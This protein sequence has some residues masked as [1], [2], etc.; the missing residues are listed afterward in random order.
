M[1]LLMADLPLQ[2]ETKSPYSELIATLPDEDPDTDGLS[3]A[4][5]AEVGSNPKNPDTDGDGLQDGEDAVAII[6]AMKV[7]AAKRTNYAIIDLGPTHAVGWPK[8][9]ND[10]GQVLLVAYNYSTQQYQGNLWEGGVVRLVAELEGFQGEGFHGL[11]NDGTVYYSIFA[12][13]I[14]CNNEQNCYIGRTRLYKWKDGARTELNYSYEHRWLAQHTHEPEDPILE[15]IN[16]FSTNFNNNRSMAIAAAVQGASA[17]PRWHGYDVYTFEFVVEDSIYS[18]Q[19]V[20]DGHVWSYKAYSELSEVGHVDAYVH[21]S[22]TVTSNNSVIHLL[23]DVWSADYW[24]YDDARD[25]NI[26]IVSGTYGHGGD[27]RYVEDLIVNTEGIAIGKLTTYPSQQVLS[28]YNGTWQAIP[29]CSDAYDMTPNSVGNGEGPY[30]LVKKEGAYELMCYNGGAFKNIGLPAAPSGWSTQTGRSINNHLILPMGNS[31]WR[32]GHRISLA[33]L[34][35]NPRN[36]AEISGWMVSPNT[37]WLIGSAKKDENG[38]GVFN[39]SDQRHSILL[40]PADIAVDSNR[41]GTI[42][43]AGNFQ[44]TQGKP[45]DTTTEAKPFRFWCNDDEDGTGD[46]FEVLGG[47]PDYADNQINSKRDLEDFSR[48]YVHIGA[49]YEELANG[50]F[51]IGLKWGGNATGT[52]KVKVYKFADAAGSD[53]YLKDDA[54]ATAQVSGDYKTAL[55]EVSGSTPLVLPAELFA[56]YSEANPKVCLLF[57]SSGEGKGQLCI[58]IHKADGTLIGEGPGVWLDLLDIKKMYVRAKGTPLDGV[59]APYESYTS[60]PNPP[61]TGYVDDP[62]GHVF[63]KP[64][65][66]A[67]S[68]VVFVHGIHAPFTNAT[69]AYK[70]NVASAEI[71]YKRLW[72]QGFKGRF[73]FYKW[74]ALNPAGFG[75]TGF[76]FN[77]SEYRAWK[78]GCG[79]AGFVNSISKSSK[80]LY[81][82]SQGNI[83]CGAALTDYG[84]TVDNYVLTQAAVPAGCYDVSGGQ[85]DP[86]SINGYPRFWNKEASKPTPDLASDLGYRGYL[87][88]LGVSGNVV[89]FHNFDDYALAS[90]R[91][92]WLLETH[93]E[94]NQDTYKPDGSFSNTNWYTYIQA[95]ADGQRCQL[96]D[97]FFVGRFVT[98]PHES[99]SLLARPRSKAVGA[100]ASV[101]G[102]IDDEFN[103]AAAPLA[104]SP[105]SDDH[106]AQVG[107][108]IQQV[109]LYYTELGRKLGVLPLPE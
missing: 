23:A 71:V 50:T 89:N 74:P 61:P 93:W 22:G 60:Q 106:G 9:V 86:S 35:G 39:N 56:G 4:E 18:L 97:A 87:D 103:L 33:Q 77:G 58:T 48:L 76:E 17:D 13:S 14:F 100:R 52:P 85:S 51:Q 63:S 57:E 41:D 38:D 16:V 82:H 28:I 105:S 69:D 12:P 62:N 104:F 32:N 68:L 30:F 73:A 94:A 43:F 109:W 20:N 55:G 102:S 2:A 1:V 19:R 25:P 15:D 26:D 80:N 21:E 81:A 65:D 53:S 49:F 11:L 67:D 36:W 7:A 40:V 79:L 31:I 84:L 59:T 98:D 8:G 95:N 27:G 34:C 44:S 78:Y 99:M 46:G 96:V 5:E 108:R 107:R 92:L 10:Q 6:Y 72:H 90:G 3:N 24:Y 91:T 42:R 45:T 70:A 54:A 29:N 47:L 37:D 64:H 88:T 75:S 101:Q 83:V 66:E